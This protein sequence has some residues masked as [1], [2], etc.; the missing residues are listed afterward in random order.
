MTN[1]LE[2]NPSTGT[3]NNRMVS[4]SF[5]V[6]ISCLLFSIPLAIAY[7]FIF[8]QKSFFLQNLTLFVVLFFMA[9][10]VNLLFYRV[11]IMNE[12]D[13]KIDKLSSQN[14][15]SVFSIT[16]ASFMI[17]AF[18][19]FG[20]S[21]NT[22]LVSIFENTL[23]YLYI[24]LFGLTD[25]CNTIF[26]SK[27]MDP[28]REQSNPDEFNYNFLIT[29]INLDNLEE[30]ISYGKNCGK[31]GTTSKTNLMLDF[32]LKFE[33]D[34]QANKLRDLVHLKYTFGHYIWIYLASIVSFFVSMIGM[35]L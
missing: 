12:I 11:A 8:H 23:G 21:M 6:I 16:L 9:F 26:K 20:L 10:T 27:T 32:N 13:A 19:L 15:S 24:H 4:A 22:N 5:G 29:Q 34:D 31:P 33:Y 25:L 1:K 30:I 28:I 7:F 2:I 35:A 17:V 14:I 18:T 3:I